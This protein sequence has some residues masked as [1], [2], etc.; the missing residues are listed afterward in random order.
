MSI[1]RGIVLGVLLSAASLG[2][3]IAHTSEGKGTDWA[4]LQDRLE[5]DMLCA[6]SACG[7]VCVGLPCGPQE[8]VV[9]NEAAREES[10]A[11][12]PVARHAVERPEADGNLVAAKPL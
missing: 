8:T 9:R 12:R 10:V 2:F 1:D 6:S 5:V 7:N 11:T 4:K 3:A